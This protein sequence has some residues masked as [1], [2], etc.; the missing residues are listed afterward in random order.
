MALTCSP[1]LWESL[2]LL[3]SWTFEL[4][5]LGFC[6]VAYTVPVW[7]ISEIN[8]AKPEASTCLLA[9]SCKLS[10]LWQR[11]YYLCSCES[12]LCQPVTLKLGNKVLHAKTYAKSIHVLVTAEV[13]LYYVHAMTQQQQKD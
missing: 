11:W 6:Q 9:G 1:L 8:S 4:V 13:S 2:Q 12:L 5:I 3:P 10:D 7:H